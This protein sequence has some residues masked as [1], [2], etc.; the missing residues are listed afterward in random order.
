MKVNS[1][2]LKDKFLEGFVLRF[3]VHFVV[4]MELPAQL[5]SDSLAHIADLVALAVVVDHDDA[6]F[7]MPSVLA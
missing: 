2:S 7:E 1:I 4:P 5:A 3:A 6:Y